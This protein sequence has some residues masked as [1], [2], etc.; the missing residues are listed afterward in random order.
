MVSKVHWNS[1]KTKLK[2]S[3]KCFLRLNWVPLTHVTTFQI[4]SHH[5]NLK[6]KHFFNE[7]SCRDIKTK[8]RHKQDFGDISHSVEKQYK[9]KT[10]IVRLGRIFGCLKI[11]SGSGSISSY[12]DTRLMFAYV[13]SK[14]GN[15]V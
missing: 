12:L 7:R 9:P 4:P 14:H 3:L 2:F 1:Y 6:F 5:Y 10:D 13:E 11:I 15:I 8:K